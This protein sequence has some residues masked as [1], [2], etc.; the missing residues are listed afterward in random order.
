M[1]P[2]NIQ[3]LFGSN[4]ETKHLTRQSTELKQVYA[5]TIVKYMSISVYDVKL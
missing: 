2:N 5:Q 3:Q 1:L 4:C